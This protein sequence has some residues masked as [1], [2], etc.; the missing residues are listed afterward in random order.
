VNSELESSAPTWGDWAPLVLAR[1]LRASETLKTAV[2]LR[3]L[4]APA[5]GTTEL[6]Y[7][8]LLQDLI[9][10]RLS[11]WADVGASGATDAVCVWWPV[12][13]RKTSGCRE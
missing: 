7:Q 4:T 5:A 12:R 8:A 9:I 10:N 3:L 1:T 13:P 6:R 11:S 2:A